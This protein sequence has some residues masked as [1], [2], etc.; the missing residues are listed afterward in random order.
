[1]LIKIFTRYITINRKRI[2]HQEGGVFVFEVTPEQN[3]E[4]L[5]KKAKS[6]KQQ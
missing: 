2:Y 5:K 1:M 6:K 4:Y 3:E